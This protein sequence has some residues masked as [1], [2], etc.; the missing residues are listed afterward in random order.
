MSDLPAK[1][2]QLAARPYHYRVETEPGIPGFFVACLEMRGCNAEGDT[3]TEA[4]A[5]F[6]D[7]KY[8]Y[9]LRY[10]EN[11]VPV[12]APYSDAVTAGAQATYSFTFEAQ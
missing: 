2:R 1:A 4:L 9:I 6:E 12:P 5:D 11:G 3:W 8:W 7:V 10:L